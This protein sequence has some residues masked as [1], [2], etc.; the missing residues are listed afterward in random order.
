MEIFSLRSCRT[1]GVDNQSKTSYSHSDERQFANYLP[2]VGNGNI[3]I[4]QSPKPGEFKIKLPNDPCLESGTLSDNRR[5]PNKRSNTIVNDFL[6]PRIPCELKIYRSSYT[7]DNT[8]LYP[9][10]FIN[11]LTPSGF[12]PY[13]LKLK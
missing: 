4:E 5:Y 1:S 9:L 12:P 2:D 11:K 10:E 8:C 3:S 7:V 13:I 6:L